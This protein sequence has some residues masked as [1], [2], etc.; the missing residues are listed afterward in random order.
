MP[1]AAGLGLVPG[2]TRAA[3]ES[4]PRPP[5]LRSRCLGAGWRE[6]PRDPRS[7]RLRVGLM[8]LALCSPLGPVAP[9]RHI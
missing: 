7:E 5:Q 3:T 9:A 6:G 2:M 1:A 8:Q 4:G